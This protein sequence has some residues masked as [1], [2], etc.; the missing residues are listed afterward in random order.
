MSTEIEKYSFLA[1]DNL[2]SSRSKIITNGPAVREL[3]PQEM[4]RYKILDNEFDGFGDCRFTTDFR[5]TKVWL[6][7]F[8]V[9]IG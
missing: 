6:N 2:E 4:C 7:C 5:R 3:M 9:E 8:G 1:L